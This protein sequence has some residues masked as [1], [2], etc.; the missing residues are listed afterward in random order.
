MRNCIYSFA[1]FGGSHRKSVE[2]FMSAR[3][4]CSILVLKF[5]SIAFDFS[6]RIDCIRTVQWYRCRSVRDRIH[7]ITKYMKRMWALNKRKWPLTTAH[8]PFTSSI[9]TISY[10]QF[11]PLLSK[12]TFSRTATKQIDCTLRL[13]SWFYSIY[14]SLYRQ[15][16]LGHWIGHYSL[17]CHNGWHALPK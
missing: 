16:V 9:K 13:L 6:L 4:L 11:G 10:A 15:Y 5:D 12:W 7:L 1:L 14:S 3:I 8:F 17:S 2:F